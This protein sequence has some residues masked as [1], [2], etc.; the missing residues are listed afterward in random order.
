MPYIEKYR[1]NDQPAETAGDLH[2]DI[3]KL[4]DLYLS[5]QVT[6]EPPH[7]QD[8]N[9]VMGVLACAQAELYRRIIGPYE[10]TKREE[11]GDVYSVPGPAPLDHVEAG[12]CGGGGGCTCG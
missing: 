11:N 7:Y 12:C 8:F 2:Y 1:R 10:D 6:D 5:R 3:A 9:D 4:I